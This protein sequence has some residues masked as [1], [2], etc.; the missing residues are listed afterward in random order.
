MSGKANMENIDDVLQKASELNNSGRYEEAFKLIEAFS[1]NGD[2][3]AQFF[4]AGL[5]EQGYGADKDPNRAQ[6]LLFAAAEKGHAEAQA[7]VGG[8]YALGHGVDIDYEKAAFW[9]E[10]A[11]RQGSASALND[12]GNMHSLGLFYE[13]N[14]AHAVGLYQISAELGN[15]GGQYSYGQY[16][17]KIAEQAK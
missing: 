4:L 13:K 5:L 15:P 12:L 8:F 10:K 1:K 3:A 9:L 17:L 6:Q 11:A 14:E 7:R 2:P 16:L